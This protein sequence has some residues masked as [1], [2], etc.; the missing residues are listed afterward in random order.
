[1]NTMVK[2]S[3]SFCFL[4]ALA[5]TFWQQEPSDQQT[6][7]R[8]DLI[9]DKELSRTGDAASYM[10][11]KKEKRA[12][13][14][15]KRDA[16]EMHAQI[17]RMRRTPIGADGPQYDHNHVFTEYNKARKAQVRSP[18]SNNLNFIERG[19]SNVAGRTRALLVVPGDIGNN[20]WIAG[21]SSGGIW[22]TTD[23]GMSWEDKTT[24]LPNLGTNTLAMSESNPDVIYAGTGEHFTSDVDGSGMFKSEDGG[25]TWRQIVDPAVLTD[26][27]NVSRIIVDPN[28]ANIAL[29]TTRNSVWEDSLSAAIYKTLDGGETWT[30]KLR[31]E[32]DR[33]DDLNYNP[34]NFST[35]YVAIRGRG[36]IKSYDAG[37]T[38][39]DASSGL[40]P[41]GRVEIAISDVDTSR[42]WASVQGNES[43]TGSDLYVS[44]NAG[45]TW[46][47]TIER[48]GS[49]VGF[50]GGQGWYDNIV[51][52][53]PF[54]RDVCYVGGINIWKMEVTQRIQTK[55][56]FDVEFRGTEEFLNFINGA[57]IGGGI[58]R[59]E[60]LAESQYVSVE[61][62]FGQG[63]Q[64]AHR[65][66]VDGRGSGVPAGDYMYKDLVEIP[67]QAWDAT[68]DRQLMVS[69]RDQADDEEWSLILRSLNNLST[70]SREYIFV[71]LVPYA[72][73]AH[74]KIALDG[75]QEFRQLYFYWPV[76]RSNTTFNGVEQD[77]SIFGIY[78]AQLQGLEKNTTNISDAYGEFGQRNGFSN[79]QFENNE[80]V[81]PDQHNIITIVTDQRT[82]LFKMISTN[83]GGVYV[84]EEGLDPGTTDGSY[85]YAGFGYNTTQFYGADKAPGTD[86]YIGGMQDNSTWFTPIGETSDDASSQYDFAFGGDGFEALWNNRDGNQI[87]GSIQFN[88]L[89]R[90]PDGGQSWLGATNG[91]NND[92]PF[93]SRLSNSRAFPDQIFTVGASGVYRS[94]DFGQ[95]WVSIPIEEQWSFNNNIDIEVSHAS[96]DYIWTGGS[97]SENLRPFVS[98]DGGRTFTATQYYQDEEMGFMSGIGTHPFNVNKGYALFSFAD[99][100]KVLMTEDLGDTWV[101]ISGYAES[102]NGVSARGFPDVAVNCLLVFPNDTTRIWIGTEI[103][104]VESLDEGLS[105]SLL[106]GNL[107]AVNV[108]DFKIQDDQIVIATYGRGIWS[109][110]VDGIEREYVFAPIVNNALINPQGRLIIQST[111]Y[112]SFDST[113][114]M[115]A[116]G[117]FGNSNNVAEGTEVFSLSNL[118]LPEGDYAVEVVGYIEGTAY[119]SQPKSVY[120]YQPGAPS[121]EY[122][123]DLSNAEARL[124][125]IGD[126]FEVRLDDG[127]TDEAIHSNHNYADR[128]EITYQIKTPWVVADSQ[129]FL[130]RDIAIIEPGEPG[131]KFGDND[132]YD[133]VVVEATTDGIDWTP[134]E[135]GYDARANSTWLS[136]YNQGGN[137]TS[138][139]YVDHEIDLKDQFTIGDTIFVRFRLSSDPA[140]NSYG[141]VIDDIE[142]RLDMT[143]PVVEVAGESILVYPNPTTDYLHVDIPKNVDDLEILLT[144]VD[145][146]TLYRKRTSESGTTLSIDVSQ[147][148]RGIYFLSIRDGKEIGVTKIYID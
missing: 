9:Q 4:F 122:F 62:R 148:A 144:N 49:E 24:D 25:E 111:Y 63:T 10:R 131:S 52:A 5:Y 147:Y 57:S 41:N 28:D 35:Q 120:I 74:A 135:S 104:I 23:G 7:D 22:K 50:L 130:Y 54:D 108:Y 1:M 36:V 146:S 67:F 113:R 81:H 100:P 143:S 83:D 42:L 77:S 21:S 93:V 102:D 48:F 26:F 11:L 55:T 95:N 37:E 137:G 6:Q 72:D 87:I 40:R 30:R 16:P 32:D 86:R 73:T 46:E 8:V 124:D 92:G 139:L 20:T 68:N 140:V 142:L 76:L 31:S 45:R 14:H 105:W 69:F 88:S 91:L 89:L 82:Q 56:T 27:R 39:E 126:G 133:F 103:G 15:A 3:I 101:D 136:T 29:A 78:K 60:D 99:K 2:K 127:F 66:S 47:L 145:G 61:L 59:G 12:Q 119:A 96:P 110:Q 115:L 71:H 38:W 98:T 129:F 53:H 116:D 90:S 118:N 43:G 107:P 18:K 141:W 17:E 65:F 44:R 85:S 34:A 109:V 106:E 64:M 75:G 80:G 84:S 132:F 114:L 138:D 51:T 123:N 112:N 94:E 13:G 33:Y 58:L 134:V 79:A 70:D 128:I 19:P 125:F 97:M 117:I 121:H